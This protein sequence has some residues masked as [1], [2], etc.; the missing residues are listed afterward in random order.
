MTREGELAVSKP[1][2]VVP[3]PPGPAMFSLANIVPAPG[4]SASSVEHGSAVDTSIV[5]GADCPPP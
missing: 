4:S 5:S 3:P 1:R 2:R